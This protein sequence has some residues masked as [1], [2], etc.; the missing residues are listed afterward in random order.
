MSWKAFKEENQMEICTKKC[1]SIHCLLCTRYE[2]KAVMLVLNV[3]NRT[4][5][6]LEWKSMPRSD[7]LE[8]QT[9]LLPLSKLR[10]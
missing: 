4:A 10:Y 3:F 1:A 5:Y 2:M 9:N 8:V 6:A 7:G